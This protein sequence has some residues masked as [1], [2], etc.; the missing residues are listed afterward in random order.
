[1]YRLL[2]F[3]II[4]LM[5]TGCAMPTSTG[6]KIRVENAWARP[7]AAS[8]M[9]GMTATPEMPGMAASGATSAAYFVIV[10]EGDEA[11]ALIGANAEVA[12]TAELHETRIEGNVAKMVPVTRVEIPA[13]GRVEFKPGSYHVM[14]VGLKRDLKAGETLKL[15]L[16][17]EKS[18]ALT[19]D[20]PIRQEG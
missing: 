5:L 10:N 8:S 6:P 7:T 2:S 4:L 15:T 13:H 18:G 16:Q 17:F 1:M 12:S 11:D 3:S 14:L 20:A 9:E 19:L